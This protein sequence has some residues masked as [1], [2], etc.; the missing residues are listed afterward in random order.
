M[1]RKCIDG[2]IMMADFSKAFDVIDINFVSSCLEKNNFGTVFQ[3][4]IKILYTDIRS[5]VLVN[6]W[7]SESF[8]I[9]RGVRQGCPLSALLFVLA[10]ELLS[11]RI[12]NNKSITGISVLKPEENCEVK[13]LQYA[14]D[15]L[16][17]VSDKRSLEII[18]EELELFGS[19]AGP[20]L[21]KTKTAV[22]WLGDIN[23]KWSLNDL[24]LS[25][26]DAPTKYL[27][28]YISPSMDKARTLNW[29][30][31]LT[32]LQ[33]LLDNWRKRKLTLFGRITIVKTLALSQIV[34]ILMVDTIPEKILKRLNCLIYTFIW[35]TKIEKVKRSFH[36][37][38]V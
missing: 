18:N 28:F 29:E 23:S 26:T 25:W 4:W 15:T 14:D 7:I 27:G 11:N 37:Q 32:K 19:V 36:D 6:G 24:G 35:Q 38:A 3:S 17:F 20:K 22:M 34:H 13:L 33:R 30:N 31:K 9:Q 1:K 12:R 8:S 10:A 2:A 16:F 21:N 5:S